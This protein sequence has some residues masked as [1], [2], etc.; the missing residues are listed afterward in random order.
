M[1]SQN[2]QQA[3]ETKYPVNVLF[4]Q[5]EDR[6][7]L[8]TDK[9]L[10]SMGFAGTVV[11]SPAQFLRQSTA[12]DGWTVMV[13]DM[14]AGAQQ[15]LTIIRHVRLRLGYGPG[16][17]ILTGR[18]ST[19]TIPGLEAGADTFLEYDEEPGLLGAAVLSLVRLV[20]PQ[21]SAPVMTQFSGRNILDKSTGTQRAHCQ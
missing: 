7:C 18:R 5:T 2:R 13:V 8:E 11:V 19:M 12:M 10:E 1:G 14:R 17:L 16:I 4:V 21:S 20:A 3:T 9:Q 6:L 15:G